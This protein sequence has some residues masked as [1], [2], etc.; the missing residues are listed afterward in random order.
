MLEE[1]R[2]NPEEWKGRSVLFLHT[3]GLLGLYG[4]VGQLQTLLEG[5][6]VHRLL[7]H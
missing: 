7:V 2:A 3:G 6:R 5:E 1:I 4:A